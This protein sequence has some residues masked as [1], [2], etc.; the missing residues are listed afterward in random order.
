MFHVHLVKCQLTWLPSV[1]GKLAKVMVNHSNMFHFV[2]TITMVTHQQMKP[3]A[4]NLLSVS[5]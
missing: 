3:L 2:G 4:G 5:S 1:N